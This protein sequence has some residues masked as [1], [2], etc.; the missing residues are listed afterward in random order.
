[1]L[2]DQVESTPFLLVCELLELFLILKITMVMRLSFGRQLSALTGMA[3]FARQ[4]Q[5]RPICEYRSFF[6]KR[7][8]Q[9]KH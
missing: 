8:S 5:V 6:R 3:K 9:W 1:M 7:Q 2:Q 4:V